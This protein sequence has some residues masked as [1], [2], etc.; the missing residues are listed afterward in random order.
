MSL[1]SHPKNCLQAESKRITYDMSVIKNCNA[2]MIWI[3]GPPGC[4]RTTQAEFLSQ[5]LNF[6]LIS[7]ALLIKKEANA[8]SKRGQII[9]EILKDGNKKVPDA[10]IIFL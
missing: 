5:Y 10:S 7:T 9:S 4:G 1:L 2:P 3:V 8:E 6:E